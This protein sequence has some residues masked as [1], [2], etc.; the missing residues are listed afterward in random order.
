[1]LGVDSKANATLL[2]ATPV[3]LTALALLAAGATGAGAATS[4]FRLPGMWI[5]YVN[6]TQGGD[7]VK[8]ATWASR[9]K[10]KTVFIKSGDGPNYWSQFDGIVGPLKQLGLRV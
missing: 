3:M 7:P 2:R 6:Q 10:V 1:M 5:W 4:S 9:F 8:I